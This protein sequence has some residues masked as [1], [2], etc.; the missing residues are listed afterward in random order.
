MIP[1]AKSVPVSQACAAGNMPNVS[2]AIQGW[3]Q[4]LAGQRMQKEVQVGGFVTEIPLTFSISGVVQPLSPTQVMLKPEGQRTWIWKM[5]HSPVGTDIRPDDRIVID[6][7]KYRVMQI[8]P[9]QLDGYVQFDCTQDFTGT[10][11]AATTVPVS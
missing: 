5:I 3:L 2:D 6:C 10:T 4:T 9:Y 11:Q 7:V 8:Y 1:N